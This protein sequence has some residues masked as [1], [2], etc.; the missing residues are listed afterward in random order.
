MPYTLKNPP[1]W[2][3]NM[4]PG[5]Q[6]IA[7]DVF[8][9]VLEETK[10]EEKAR[11]AAISSVKKLYEKDASTGRWRRMA[12]AKLS[13]FRASASAETV[14]DI[15]TSYLIKSSADPETVRGVF[16]EKGL[17]WEAVLIEPGISKGYPRY[18]WS[19]EVLSDAVEK[20]L[21]TGIDINAYERKTDQGSDFNHIA[22][23]PIEVEDFKRYLVKEKVGTTKNVKYINGTGVVADIEFRP[24]QAWL[25]HLLAKNNGVLGLSIDS[26]IG[27]IPI[28]V[29]NG[30]FDYV[31]RI[32]SVSSVDV[33]TRPAAGGR[34]RRAVE[35]VAPAGGE[36][37]M[38]REELI[39]FLKEGGFLNGVE[40][41]A[42]AQ[43][44]ESDLKE[45]LKG[46]VKPAKKEEA[47]P[48]P[49]GITHEQFEAGITR[50]IQTS[51]AALT[52]P[53]MSVEQLVRESKKEA[54]KQI[55]ETVNM[56]QER[57]ACSDYLH[58]KCRESNLP[59]RVL[60]KMIYPRFRDKIFKYEDLD[61]AIK[62]EVQDLAQMQVPGFAGLDLNPNAKVG[63]DPGLKMRLSLYKLMGIGKDDFKSLNEMT[64]VNHN[65]IFSA[66]MRAIQAD[67]FD[68]T[69]SGSLRQLYVDWTGDNEIWGN[70]FDISNQFRATQA[71]ISPTSF[72]TALGDAMYRRLVMA[73]KEANFNENIWI[74][75]KTRLKD[76]NPQNVVMVGYFSD[77]PTVDPGITQDYTELTF[78][79][80]ESASY[81]LAQRGGILSVNRKTI[82]ND[83]IGLVKDI[84]DR[85]GRSARRTYAKAVW[86]FFINNSNC[87][88]GTAWFTLAHNNLLTIALNY[89]NA[90]TAY[91]ALANMTEADSGE[92]IGWLAD[93]TKKPVL[94]YPQALAATAEGVI[95]DEHYYAASG[96][97][98]RTRNPCYGKI[99]GALIPFAT[100]N[101]DWGM[102][103]PK[104][105]ASLIEMGFL[106]GRETPIMMLINSSQ[107]QT[108]VTTDNIQYK[109]LHEYNGIC[110]DPRGAIQSQVT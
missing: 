69:P 55:T 84:V 108:N 77:I 41:D 4:P 73:Y 3:E 79:T 38:T 10:D 92:K 90:W 20:G 76:F 54:E 42:I 80:E 33:V 6:R 32:D 85:L 88:D 97:D 12:E 50:A 63:P 30:M 57:A 65:P 16:K 25:P 22:D 83:N 78:P 37:I 93:A 107:N 28:S 99:A 7:V 36:N 13:R 60:E 45:V 82:I 64:D 24:D 110:V 66:D 62:S 105:E 40:D 59:D 58:Q 52:Q 71:A 26:R 91:T 61:A 35:S 46:S 56:I 9:R 17:V 51:L 106:E 14:E 1:E 39:Q 21:F 74:S 68:Y 15:I 89:T 104:T 44:S 103:M 5:A 70:Y 100:D 102:I 109:L 98:S 95:K 29:E 34:F 43:M 49:Q 27:K 75:K 67:D 19:D 72:P 47:E 18:I 23:A 31:T 86:G 101:D 2:S 53:A 48:Q 11:I 96:V 94:L 81:S 8:N 87:I